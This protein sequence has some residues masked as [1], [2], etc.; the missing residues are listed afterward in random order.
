[1]RFRPRPAQMALSPGG[2]WGRGRRISSL[3]TCKG[4]GGAKV[5]PVG[6]RVWGLGVGFGAACY[7]VLKAWGLGKLRGVG[8]K[9]SADRVRWATSCLMPERGRS[10][11]LKLGF[12]E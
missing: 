12:S 5:E 9:A 3:L 11:M 6:F 2:L 4:G 7:W 8:C 1:M 10:D